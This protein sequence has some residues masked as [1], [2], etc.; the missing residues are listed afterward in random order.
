MYLG[1][2]NSWHLIIESLRNGLTTGLEQIYNVSPA[3]YSCTVMRIVGDAAVSIFASFLVRT[4]DFFSQDRMTLVARFVEGWRMEKMIYPGRVVDCK[5]KRNFWEEKRID[6]ELIIIFTDWYIS[7]LVNG[8]DNSLGTRYINFI[9]DNMRCLS[10]V[11]LV[12]DCYKY[13][14]VLRW[15]K[16]KMRKRDWK[17]DSR[18]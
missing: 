13:S 2:G 8:W 7:V 9:T 12:I 6:T 16:I 10:A 3:E 4:R 11:A 1:S 14:L 15:Y 17:R 18:G 5:K